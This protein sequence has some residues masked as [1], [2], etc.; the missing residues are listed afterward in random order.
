MTA[1]D[2]PYQVRRAPTQYRASR[3]I[4]RILDAASRVVLDK[5]YAAATTAD[6]AR[7]AKVSIGSVYRYFPDKPAVMKAVVE[8]NILR[9]LHRVQAESDRHTHWAA[10][11]EHAY[12]IYIDMC[13]ADEGFRAIGGA[14]L[15]LGD[16]RE[17]GELDVP[18]ADALAA[19]L[20]A[21]YGFASTAALRVSMLQ[22]VTVGEVMA[23]LAFRLRG[24]GHP[25]TLRQGRRIVC[26]LIGAHAPP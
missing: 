25:E 26:D 10:A 4:E 14:G 7:S 17:S 12:D 18:L 23:R 15:A 13:R 21:R 22:S 24:E 2:T 19:V 5:G 8:R 9:Y 6:I 20:V 3:Q 16:L 1:P 11:V